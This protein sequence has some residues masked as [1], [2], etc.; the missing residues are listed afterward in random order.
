[1]YEKMASLTLSNRL[2][3]SV[4]LILVSKLGRNGL[5]RDSLANVAKRCHGTLQ[6]VE[7]AMAD[8][9]DAGMINS[10]EISN[11]PGGPLTCVVN[12]ELAMAYKPDE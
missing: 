2:A 5:V 6:Q 8:L 3:A 7:K 11:E 10:V 9:V 4:M 12:P 1:M